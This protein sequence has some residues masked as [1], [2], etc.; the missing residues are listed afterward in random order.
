MGWLALFIFWP[1]EWKILSFLI[2]SCCDCVLDQRSINFYFAKMKPKNVRQSLINSNFLG[3][4]WF[5]FETYVRSQNRFTSSNFSIGSLNSNRIVKN[6]KLIVVQFFS[7]TEWVEIF[8]MKC[9]NG[10]WTPTVAIYSKA[11]ITCNRK[12]S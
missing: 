9:V 8:F 2:Q 6:E 10:Q 1:F 7:E 5:D 4:F 12:K 11:Q 3:L